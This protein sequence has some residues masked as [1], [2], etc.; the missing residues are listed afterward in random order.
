MSLVKYLRIVVI[1]LLF[2]SCV[3]AQKFGGNPSGIKW[4]Q[5]NSSGARVI[6]PAGLDSQAKR[7]HGILELLDTA[8]IHT[9]GGLRRK[10]NT[11]VLNQTTFSNAYVRLAPVLSEFYMTPNQNNFEE[12]GLRWDDNL[13]I[14]ENRHMQQLANFNKGVTKV[15]S[16]L[17]GQQGQLLANGITIP[18]YF[19][20][21][22][23]V[24][25]ETLVSNQGRGRI[26]YFYNGFKAL[27]QEKK[28]YSWM[29][30]RSGSY[31]DFTPDHYPLGYQLIA[32]GTATYGESFWKK[33]TQDAV[34]FKGIFYPFNK[35]I[36]KYS[37][38]SYR[39]FRQDALD[40]F[41]VQS[42]PDSTSTQEYLY[43]TEIKR[44]NV[45]DY[46]YPV[47]VTDD[48]ILVTKQSY[49]ETSAFYLLVNGK[50]KKLRIKNTTLDAYYSYNHGKI[51][52]AS[53]QSDPRRANRDYSVLQVVD[54]KTGTQ[55]QITRKSKYFSPDINKNATEIVAVQVNTDGTN[56]LHRIDANTGALLM[57]LPNPNNY[58]F[59]Q[60]RYIDAHYAAA[61]V[62][63]ASGKIALLKI[64][65]ANGAADTLIDFSFGILGFPF[66]KD[67]SVYFNASSGY[68]D[69]IFAVNMTTKKIVSV[70]NNSNGVYNPVVNSRG[71]VL[72]SAF[73]SG[74]FRLLKIDRPAL[75]RRE[76]EV[77]EITPLTNLYTPA[78]LKGKAAGVLYS[79]IESKA[80]ATNYKKSFQLFNF[81]SRVA[82][83]SDPEYGYTFSGNNVLSTFSNN[84]TYTYNRNEKSHSVG[85]EAL[86]AGFFPVFSIGAEGSFNRNGYDPATASAV[87]FNS[88][89]I[90]A[91]VSLPLSFVG[92]RT[93]K[94]FN[95]GTRY[96][97]EQLYY[98]GIG[99]NIFT[100]K[101]LH[102]TNSF[103]SFSNIN[104]QAKQQ[105]SPR[106]AQSI[107][108]GYRHAFTIRESRKFV[109]S[110]NFYF[111]GLFPN[112]SL[113]LQGAFQKRDTL[114]DIF[115]NT[116][117]YSRGYQALSSRRMY[118]LGVNYQ[119]P[120]WYPDLGF[121]N[122][123][124]FQRIRSNVYYDH[125]NV[126]IRLSS[127]I[128]TEVI[129]RSTGAEIF[130]DT[131]VWNALPVSFGIR[132]A[133]LL[134]TDLRNPLTVNR[135]EFVLFNFIPQ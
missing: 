80:T 2:P 3:Y 85:Y 130:F 52:Y 109:S 125:T 115:S 41:K 134:D 132:Y 16:F 1:M 95:I 133:R 25:Q 42:F 119:L 86:Y 72:A 105:V 26:P 103:I 122:I 110:A 73:T 9:I 84:I 56:Y 131:K 107:T 28:R 13:A 120:V 101:P 96:N 116:F 104:R 102:Y 112:H 20:E 31:R 21:G 22:D 106:W 79:F 51:V 78:A 48:T 46:L 108:A 135:W 99:K 69:K 82:V 75:S 18:D 37:G 111:P 92:G 43:L 10:W 127:G 97:A 65:L 76:L 35:A 61:V 32:Y 30:L 62:R 71:E 50:E 15:F 90:Y 57:Q 29:K 63:N 33:V 53:Y 83:I 117:S 74:G 89:K 8:T 38:K 64:D 39:Q 70:S 66:V 54:I 11:V 4:R 124:F 81:H 129:N 36:Q 91:G 58:F 44:N 128:L 34:R 7:I 114:P 55:K 24:W 94:F 23:A 87:N 113:V 5:I 121:G 77:N 123:I 98:T 118:K 100:N 27:W 68:T 40:F 93:N 19:F 47:Y 49:S 67:D 14:H 17:L 88:A 59:T 60:T 12:G 45:V 126:Q 6:F